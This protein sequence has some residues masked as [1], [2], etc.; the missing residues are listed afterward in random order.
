MKKDKMGDEKMNISLVD[1]YSDDKYVIIHTD[2]GE[3][4]VPQKGGPIVHKNENGEMVSPNSE[5]YN[6][7]IDEWCHHVEENRDEMGEE[8]EF[9][10]NGSYDNYNYDRSRIINSLRDSEK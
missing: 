8:F 4:Y 9:S 5:D 2:H 3:F 6:D 10:S 7:L 1:S